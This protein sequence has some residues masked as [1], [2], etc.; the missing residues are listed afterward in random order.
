VSGGVHN[1]NSLTKDDI[2]TLPA[3]QAWKTYYRSI[4]P[5]LSLC[6]AVNPCLMNVLLGVAGLKRGVSVQSQGVAVRLTM[7]Q[8]YFSFGTKTVPPAWRQ[9]TP[10]FWM[11]YDTSAF[12]DTGQPLLLAT[13]S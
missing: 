2:K 11:T 6:L 1:V 12:N 8:Y 13:I 5:N 3:L 9:A 4:A 7:Q 10:R